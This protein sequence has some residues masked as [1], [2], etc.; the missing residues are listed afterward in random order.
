MIQWVK[1]ASIVL[2]IFD[3][4]MKSDK[5]FVKTVV[6]LRKDCPMYDVRHSHRANHEIL[7]SSRPLMFFQRTLGMA[8]RKVMIDS[9]RII[10]SGCAD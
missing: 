5:E 1:T 2:S 8:M 3:Q 4:L 7:N 10:S 6:E 9:T